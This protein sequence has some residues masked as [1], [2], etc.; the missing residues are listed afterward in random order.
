MHVLLTILLQ[1][2]RPSP[3]AVH[4]CP[5]GFPPEVVA[6]DA[7]GQPTVALSPRCAA[8]LSRLA[9]LPPA[10]GPVVQADTPRER[11]L[12][13]LQLGL[14][15][16]WSDAALPF[17]RAARRLRI[18]SEEETLFGTWVRAAART[19][20]DAAT[21]A[22]EWMA[23]RRVAGRLGESLCLDA[24]AV[25]AAACGPST[26]GACAAPPACRATAASPPSAV[27]R[28]GSGVC[29]GVS[30]SQNSPV[31]T[32]RAAAGASPRCRT[33]TLSTMKPPVDPSA[34]SAVGSQWRR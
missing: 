4:A 20:A 13:A 10:P 18:Q 11:H 14:S 6:V 22:H 3:S 23:P 28:A 1:P 29:V 33:T 31:R 25:W 19:P 8:A 21:L 26:A 16:P 15:Q 24:R 2:A 30:R 9:G 7:H 5:A 12:F 27:Y 17:A 32:K 34:R